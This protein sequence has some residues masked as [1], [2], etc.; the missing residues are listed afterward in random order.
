MYDESD[1]SLGIR[2]TA[3]DMN[4]QFNVGPF[5]VYVKDGSAALDEDGDADTVDYA[6]FVLGITDDDLDGRHYFGAAGDPLSGDV[7]VDLTAAAGLSLPVYFPSDS[8]PLGGVGNN[9]V[10]ITIAD[11]KDVISGVAG[12]V[13]ITAPDFNHIFSGV[14]IIQV[15]SNP[16]SVLDGL[17]SQFNMV[18]GSLGAV[19]AAGGRP[20]GRRGAVR[21]R[22]RQRCDVVG[23]DEDER[24]AGRPDAHGPAAAGAVQRLRRLPAGHR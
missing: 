16:A 22:H 18:T 10:S 17:K 19:F 21:G 24:G 7:T 2:V 5:S 8:M 20:T 4:F 1:L 23:P 9:I 14:N 13:D 12:S 15:L 6:G 3:T 11:L